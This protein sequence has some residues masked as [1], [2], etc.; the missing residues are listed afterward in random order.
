MMS[1]RWRWMV[2]PLQA[3]VR[4]NSVRSLTSTLDPSASCNTA[5]AP[6]PVRT[7]SRSPMAAPA[8]TEPAATR[9]RPPSVE[10]TVARGPPGAIITS[11]VSRRTYTIAIS[12]DAAAASVPNRSQRDE[13]R[14]GMSV[15]VLLPLIS[16]IRLRQLGQRLRWSSS[17]TRRLGSSILI[18]YAGKSCRNCSQTALSSD[19]A[20]YYKGA[21]KL[22][23]STF[24]SD[25]QYGGK[26][27]G[28]DLLWRPLAVSRAVLFGAEG[29]SGLDTQASTGRADSCA[30]GPESLPYRGAT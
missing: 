19:I 15:T 16:A 27:P 13:E 22:A 26:L 1:P 17:K 20:G 10:T 28:F 29:L 9:N 18:R 3:A 4:N 5:R 14:T 2:W 24:L 30:S 23:F 21:G 12:S 6:G 25:C 11:I 7:E 8:W